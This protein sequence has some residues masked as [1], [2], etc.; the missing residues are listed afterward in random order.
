MQASGGARNSSPGTLNKLFF[1]AIERFRKP[2]ALQVKKAGAYEPISSNTLADHARQ[3]ALGILEI[4]VKR[5]ERVAI[6]S[7]N[8]PEWAIADYACLTAGLTDVPIYP[9]LPA[10]QIAYILKDS[11]AVA[12]FVSNKA[13][14]EKIREIR[15][16]VPALKT[17]VAFD[18]VPGL[19]NMSMADLEK[20]GADGETSRS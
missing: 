2:N 13:Q 12:I 8:R 16:Q 5:G 3:V 7:E 14:A 20:R 15:S 10:E 19:A 4:G 11:G 18:D 6:L 9:T 1:D 17:V